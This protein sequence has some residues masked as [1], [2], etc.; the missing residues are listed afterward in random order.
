[1]L[2]SKVEVVVG[3]LALVAAPPLPEAQPVG[4]AGAARV[5]SSEA[6]AVDVA[7]QLGN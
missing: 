2:R 1:M 3:W 5:L 6:L 4:P 7:G